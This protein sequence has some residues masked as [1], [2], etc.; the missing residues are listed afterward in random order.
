MLRWR[1]SLLALLGVLLATSACSADEPNRPA[2]TSPPPSTAT[3]RPAWPLTGLPATDGI[4]QRPV[5]VAKIDN[6][7]AA[8]PQVGLAQA[9]V[10]VEELVE[11]GLTRL[12]AFY[13][14][15]L[16]SVVGPVRSIRTT[17]IGMISPTGGALVAS[18]GAGRVLDQMDAADVTVLRE[19]TTDGFERDDG[20]PVPYNVMADLRTVVSE[21]TGLE[22][23]S[24]PYLPWG[25]A[26]T[27]GRAVD[28]VTAEF[29]A[30]HTTSWT[31]DG[32]AWHRDAELSEKPFEPA[33]VLI[34]RVRTRDAGYEDPGGNP[35]PETVLTGT[36]K[37]TLLTN[38]RAIS[39]RWSKAD[40][41]SP[42]QLESANADAMVVPAGK[43]WIELVPVSGSVELH[44]GS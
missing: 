10:V 4:A 37:A 43:T 20:R 38:G 30:S 11:G 23:P 31:W 26:Q 15:R 33:S 36:G 42:F 24:K 19:G 40:A 18:G 13:H 27:R 14:S 21:A 16:P 35:V 32:A 22:A 44:Q 39:G 6:T 9:D 5:L 2:P 7:A 29:S 17:D 8:E 34:L 28:E 3:E 41:A 12:A 25:A 1:G